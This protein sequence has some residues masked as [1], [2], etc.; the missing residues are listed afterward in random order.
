MEIPVE[1]SAASYYD[2]GEERGKG[3]PC[4]M[5]GCIFDLDGTLTNTLESLSYSVNLTLQE[6][7][8][9]VITIDQCR[10][11]VGEGARRLL[12]KT[13]KVRGDEKLERLEE[14]MEIYG[15][16][17]HDNCTYHV[18]PYDGV[19]EMLA[20]LTGM[21]VH[22][23]V[24]SNKPHAQA[25]DV[26]R[27]FFGENTF[28]FVLGQ[29]DRLP[30]K[31]DP[32]GVLYLLEHMGIS[33]EDCVYAGDSETDIATARAAGVTCLSATWG[34]RSRQTLLDAGARILIDSPAQLTDYIRKH[35]TDEK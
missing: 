24:L 2:R 7:H 28:D 16:I 19:R 33:R 9:P 32:A 13:L 30:R 27:Q 10:R 21:G 35:S 4:I 15:R 29:S 17:F 1:I 5:K 26:V 8:L 23:A 22:M 11:F 18:A 25:V 34:F 14:A 6:M 3:V 20:D 31:P 12:E